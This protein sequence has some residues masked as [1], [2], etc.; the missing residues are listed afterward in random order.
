ML[1]VVG[2][3]AFPNLLMN[4]F[5]THFFSP[6]DG[7]P[8]ENCNHDMYANSPYI[9]AV[10]HHDIDGSAT[11][12]AEYC[13]NTVS[14]I[15]SPFHWNSLLR[16]ISSPLSLSVSFSLPPIMQLVSGPGGSQAKPIEL[17]SADLT[18]CAP[19]WGNAMAASQVGT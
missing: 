14:P 1:G 12:R 18:T 2:T 4:V 19:R 10:S 3:L 9:I 16:W 13:A 8:T 5:I 15:G 7:G 11:S 6:G 17:A